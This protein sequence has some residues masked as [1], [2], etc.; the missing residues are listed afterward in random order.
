MK[1]SV[2]LT[3]QEP[4]V[5]SPFEPKDFETGLKYAQMGGFDGIELIIRDPNTVDAVWLKTL[6][7][8][9]GL[10]AASI[11]VGQM[12]SDGLW[13]SS[14]DADV[15]KGAV[16]R[17]CDYMKL[18]AGI[19]YCR[20]NCGMARGVGS[21]EPKIK[22]IEM[23]YIAECLI[24]CARYAGGAGILLNLE[25]INR[26]EINNLNTIADTLAFIDRVGNPPSVGVL[27][28]TFHANIEDP[29]MAEALAQCGKK[30]FHV[31][32]ADS[33]RKLPGYGH[34]DFKP[35][36]AQLRKM[37]Y[38]GYVCLEL[39]CANGGTAFMEDAEKRMK[40]ILY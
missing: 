4:S 12:M 11:S 40:A 9:Y 25:A 22:N 19:G 6:L 2:C 14:F 17:M 34:I 29:D 39:P 33:N 35:I 5:L 32:I 10:K 3:V 31:H 36:I 38:D 7:D 21:K 30:L 24:D 28:D 16:Q 23:E 13:F 20:V 27:Y 18:A 8:K 1:T 37:H 26:Y 15:R